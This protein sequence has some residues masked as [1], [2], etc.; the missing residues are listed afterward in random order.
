MKIS[1]AITVCDELSEFAKLIDHL[2]KYKRE[3]D[4]IVVL[5]D[6]GNAPDKLIAELQSLNKSFEF[7]KYEVGV[8]NGHF[9]EWK[10]KLNKLCKGDYIFQIDADE[11]PDHRLIEMLSELLEYN[12]NVE[13]IGLPRWNTV[14]G[15]TDKHIQKWNWNVDEFNRINWPDT[16]FRIY[17]NDPNIQWAGKVH[18]R[19]VGTQQFALLPT[20]E[21]F[22]LYHPKTIEKQEKQN[23]LY[24]NLQK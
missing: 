20:N 15:I 2:L 14:E 16:Q 24:N 21:Q 9:A 3:N 8:F 12:E 5:V 4:E 11:C 1:Y 23:N 6:R 22:C 10:N 17:K 13:L 18:E 19:I 7:F